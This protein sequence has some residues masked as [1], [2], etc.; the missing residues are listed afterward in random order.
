MNGTQIK[1]EI[2]DTYMRERYPDPILDDATRRNIVI[3][4][5]KIKQ[6]LISSY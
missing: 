2:V 3:K 6:E 1:E 5:T 4:Q